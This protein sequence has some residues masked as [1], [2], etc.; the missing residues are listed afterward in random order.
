MSSAGF[1]RETACGDLSSEISDLGSSF[2]GVKE[3]SGHRILAQTIKSAQA[4]V[5]GFLST[6]LIREFATT[7]REPTKD[8]AMRTWVISGVCCV[9]LQMYQDVAPDPKLLPSSFTLV[10]NLKYHA[11]VWT[12]V[13]HAVGAML[14]N[15]AYRPSK[16]FQLINTGA[17]TSPL[18]ACWQRGERS[19]HLMSNLYYRYIVV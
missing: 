9:S 19:A 3:T 4:A 12:Q 2:L 10:S 18:N 11:E 5:R 7:S 16:S 14:S 15:V 17:A 6:L 8:V 1:S 13:F